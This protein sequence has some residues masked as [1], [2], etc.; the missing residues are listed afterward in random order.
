MPPLGASVAYPTI[1]VAAT[2]AAAVTPAAAAP[3]ASSIVVA[4]QNQVHKVTIWPLD[5]EEQRG[6][7]EEKDLV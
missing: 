2:P 5:I 6:Q 1:S 7:L 4:S 3:D